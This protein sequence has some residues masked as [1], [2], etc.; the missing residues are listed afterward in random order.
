MAIINNTSKF[1]FIHVPKAAGTSITKHLSKLTTYKDLEIG[2]THFGE[3]IQSAYLKRFG[4][5]KH[6]PAFKLKSI[7]GELEWQRM[8]TFSIVRNPYERVISTYKFLLEWS[9]TDSVLKKNIES[10]QN[11]NEYILS[12]L[13]EKTDGPDNIFKP[14]VFWLTGNFDRNKILVNFIGK[15]ES[16]ESDIEHVFERIGERSP[17]NETIPILN[18]TSGSFKLTKKAIENINKVYERDFLLLNYKKIN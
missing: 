1:I 18:K 8:F 9:G 4:F 11:I 10:F 16:I 5:S 17:K 7:I 2:G 15:V 3:S 12:D 6:I 13:W 14:Q